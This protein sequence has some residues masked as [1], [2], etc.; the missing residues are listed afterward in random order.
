[1]GPHAQTFDQN[2]GVGSEICLFSLFL[3]L[4]FS[5][6]DVVWQLGISRFLTSCAS[7][8]YKTSRR[9]YGVKYHNLKNQ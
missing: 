7:V 8:C 9:V 1:M 6:H 3:N 5:V 4:F 2:K